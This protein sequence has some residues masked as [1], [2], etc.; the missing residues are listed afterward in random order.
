M[1]FWQNFKKLPKANDRTRGD[2]FKSLG[3]WDVPP[4]SEWVLNLTLRTEQDRTL[5]GN[6][7][8][9]GALV[10][11][12][13]LCRLPFM[14]DERMQNRPQD[15]PH[16]WLVRFEKRFLGERRAASSDNFCCPVWSPVPSEVDWNSGFAMQ[17]F[18]VFSAGIRHF[19]DR[20]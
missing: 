4:L 11:L 20:N 19:S 2:F 14:E 10:R 6:E 13:E 8:S 7:G 16:S 9:V 5:R 12:P 3:I 17:K 15:Q 18:S 1:P